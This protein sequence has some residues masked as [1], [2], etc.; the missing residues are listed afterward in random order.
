MIDFDFDFSELGFPKVDFDD[1]P[2]MSDFEVEA[3]EGHEITPEERQKLYQ[4]FLEEQAK[5]SATEVQMTSEAKLQKAQQAQ[6]EIP[7]KPQQYY[8]CVCEK[9]GHTMFVKA[10]D[11][12]NAETGNAK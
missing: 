2:D 7:S 9:C 6:K 3:E 11:L 4:Q 8:K 12:W 10:E 1:I 5:Q